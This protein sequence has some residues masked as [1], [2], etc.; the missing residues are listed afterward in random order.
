MECEIDRL[1]G[2]VQRLQEYSC[3]ISEEE[4]E[5]E[6]KA[7]LYTFQ[8]VPTITYDHKIGLEPLSRA[9]AP[10]HQ[11][12]PVKSG[13]RISFGCLLDAL[14]GRYF[15]HVALAVGFRTGLGIA[16]GIVSWMACGRIGAPQQN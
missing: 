4:A 8:Y 13:S 12:K 1:T 5:A 2:L 10:S 3:C 7:L 9:A 15:E 14:P 6:G 11:E 16:G